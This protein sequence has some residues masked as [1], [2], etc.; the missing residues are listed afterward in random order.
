M[1]A[2]FTTGDSAV[3]R[4]GEWVTEVRIAG[5][6]APGTTNQGDDARIVIGVVPPR[7]GPS[8]GLVDVNKGIELIVERLDVHEIQPRERIS[9]GPTCVTRP[10]YRYAKRVV[11]ASSPS[12]TTPVVSPIVIR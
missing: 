5:Q 3:A 9:G 12:W 2:A 6:H 11:T 1:R 7:R 10:T 8:P 4:R